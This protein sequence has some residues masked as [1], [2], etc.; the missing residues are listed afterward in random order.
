VW[1]WRRGGGWTVALNLS[2]AE[3]RLDAAGE[4][5]IGTRRERDGAQFDGRLAAWEGVVLA[6]R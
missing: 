4:I 3:T 6:P 1:C 5:A 2:D